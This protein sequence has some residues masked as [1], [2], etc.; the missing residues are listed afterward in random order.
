MAFIPN[1]YYS[2]DGSKPLLCLTA[3]DGTG[4]AWFTVPDSDEVVKLPANVDISNLIGPMDLV[5]A[6]YPGIRQ[7]ARIGTIV[8]EIFPRSD[9]PDPEAADPDDDQATHFV[10]LYVV[11]YFLGILPIEGLPPQADY[12]AVLPT[13]PPLGVGPGTASTTMTPRMMTIASARVIRP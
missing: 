5:Y 9:L 12:V 10:Q 11:R 4:I 8:G 13:N 6:P 1:R 2:T 7:G 3:D